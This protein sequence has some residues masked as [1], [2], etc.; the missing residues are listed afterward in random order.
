VTGLADGGHSFEV[1]A[2]DRAGNPD[3]VPASRTW[4]VDTT[5]PDTTIT[6]GPSGLIASPNASIAFASETGAAF[7]CRIDADP[8]AA[9]TSPANL[10]GLD[11]GTHT[12]SVRA[13]DAAGNTDPTPANRTWQVQQTVLSDDFESYIPPAFSPPTSWTVS[14]GADGTAAVVTDTVKSGLQAAR[15]SES[16]NTGSFA[17]IRANLPSQHADVTIDADVRV[18]VEGAAGGNVP[19]LRLFDATGVRQ[20]SFY[21]QNASAD[22]LSVSYGVPSAT[23]STTTGKLPLATWK[24]FSVHIITGA[25]GAGVVSITLN[26]T[27]I[28]D[29]TNLTL[30]TAPVF[31][32]QLG[33]E[34]K[35]QPFQ[36]VADNVSVTEQ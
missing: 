32:V 19:L 16:A 25:A 17:M 14:R 28:L 21:R 13:G 31:T 35:K 8:Y 12:F 22:R 36:L 29:K 7:E 15:L 23:T 11:A 33:N 18:D 34:T 1:L 9:C 6:S 5:P 26:G 30:G 3:P 27:T 24:H 2:I 10:S 4:T 20:L